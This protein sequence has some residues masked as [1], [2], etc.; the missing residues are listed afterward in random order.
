MKRGDEGDLVG[1]GTHENHPSVP[2][3]GF[4]CPARVTDHM[5]LRPESGLVSA[6]APVP[7]LTSLLA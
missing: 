2:T 7:W 5:E 3:I 4:H 1:M 6:S